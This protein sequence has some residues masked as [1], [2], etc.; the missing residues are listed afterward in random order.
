[1]QTDACNYGLGAVLWQEQTDPET[2]EPK[3]YIVDMW[4][5]QMPQN[6]RHC[7]SMIHEAYAIVAACEYWQFHLIKRQ[8]IV[9]TDNQPVAN[10][11]GRKWFDLSYITQKQ[12]LRLRSKYQ[13]LHLNHIMSKD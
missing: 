10:I 7:H 4:S 6:L 12:L 11:F 8:F 1:M 2:N 13:C 3:W 5:K 9:S